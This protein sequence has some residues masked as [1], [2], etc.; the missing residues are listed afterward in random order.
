LFDFS[1]AV[2]VASPL[3][4]TL[5]EM[6]DKTQLLAMC[7]AARYNAYKVIFAVFLATV[8]NH[9]LAV[10]AGQYVSVSS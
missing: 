7:F 10:A 1:L 8:A 6:G 2:V 9:A 5:A 3:F 4:V